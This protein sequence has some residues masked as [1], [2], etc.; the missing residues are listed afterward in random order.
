MATYTGRVGISIDGLCPG[1]DQ[2][3]VIAARRLP[4]HP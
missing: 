4:Q 3:V 1:G 2:N